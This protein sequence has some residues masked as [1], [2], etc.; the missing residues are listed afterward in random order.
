MCKFFN[1]RDLQRLAR[2]FISEKQSD[3]IRL[4]G[5]ANSLYTSA[6]NQAF[7]MAIYDR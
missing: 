5:A 2:Q 6:G 3:A 4:G 1:Y 7:W